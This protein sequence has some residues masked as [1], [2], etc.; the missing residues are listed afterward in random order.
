MTED[1]QTAA[2]NA[3]AEPR[4]A[5]IRSPASARKTR[6]KS[7]ENG[8]IDFGQIAEEERK[9]YDDLRPGPGSAIST[10]TYMMGWVLAAEGDNA[11]ALKHLKRAEKAERRRPGLYLQIGEAYRPAPLARSGAA[12]RR[13]LAI[14]PLNPHAHLGLA[15]T[16]LRRARRGGDVGGAG[17][18]AAAVSEPHGPLHS[19][20]GPDANAAVFPPSRRGLAGGGGAQSQFRAGAPGAGAVLCAG[21]REKEK[22][23][24]TCGCPGDSPAPA[25]PKACG[26]QCHGTGASRFVPRGGPGGSADRLRRTP[27]ALVDKSAVPDDPARCITVVAGLP[28]SGTSMMMQMLD[29]GGLPIF[30]DQKRAADGDNPRG[31]Y[32]LEAA[33]PGCARTG[34]G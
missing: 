1:R 2:E 14:D 13:A 23:A 10:W 9:K 32:E 8:E 25:R 12:F 6:A 11:G 28:R 18:G 21:D 33:T 24:N 3:R 22:P 16:F 26:R 4:N 27:E 34:N 29:A 15:R 19:G 7:S 20:L 31:Y 5:A 30:T 17:I